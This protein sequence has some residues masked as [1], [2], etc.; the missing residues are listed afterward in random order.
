MTFARACSVGDVEPA[1]ALQVELDDTSGAARPVAIVRD[2]DG[3]WHA[4][5][6]TCSHEDYSLSEGD[7]E[8]GVI[9]CWKHGATFDLASGDALTLPATEPVPVYAIEITGDDVLVDVDA[10]MQ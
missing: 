2:S 4:L 3:T 9:E 10:T 1:G 7:V 8:D 6:D 5:G